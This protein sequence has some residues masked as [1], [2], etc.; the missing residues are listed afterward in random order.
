MPYKSEE[1]RRFLKAKKP[2]VA[3]K[4]DKD[5]MKKPRKKSLYQIFGK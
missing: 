4:F 2:K 1:Q 3:A 5:K